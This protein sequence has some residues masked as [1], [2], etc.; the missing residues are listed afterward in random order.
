MIQVLDL[1]VSPQ[2]LTLLNEQMQYL[3]LQGEILD[4]NLQK[5]EDFLGISAQAGS[6][7]SSRTFCTAAATALT[8]KLEE[9]EAVLLWKN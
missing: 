6:I 8:S 3:I 5:I 1:T 4:Q 9:E 7:L 2:V